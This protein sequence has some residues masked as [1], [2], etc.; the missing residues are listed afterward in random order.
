MP[1]SAMKLKWWTPSIAS[2]DHSEPLPKLPDFQ[3]LT[4]ARIQN[5]VM[6]QSMEINRYANY[7]IGSM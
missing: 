6:V 3:F 2:L 1:K 7:K 5:I 4:D